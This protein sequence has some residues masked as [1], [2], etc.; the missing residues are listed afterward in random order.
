MDTGGTFKLDYANIFSVDGFF[1]AKFK[2]I[3]PTPPNAVGAQGSAPTGKPVANGQPTE[4]EYVDKTPI[5]DIDKEE[6]DFGGFDEEEDQELIE[7]AKMKE[8]RRKGKNPKEVL[9]KA[10]GGAQSKKADGGSETKTSDSPRTKKMDTSAEVKEANGVSTGEKTEKASRSK[11]AKKTDGA[12][13]E[14]KT[15]D[16]T[17]SA[18][19]KS[20][21]VNGK[22][23]KT[24]SRSH[25]R[26]GG[27]TE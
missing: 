6:S 27:R 23:S 8:L 9:Y 15:N 2:K 18:A 12:T 4:E 3:G 16:G 26:S 21:G 22:A 11:K 10:K 25:R 5:E 14:K 19:A 20:N 1:V 24:K 7:R 13:T 17:L